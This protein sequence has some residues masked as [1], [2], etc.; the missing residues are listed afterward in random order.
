MLVLAVVGGQELLVC[1][2]LDLHL[3]ATGP[4]PVV[5]VAVAGACFETA[6]LAGPV[7][8]FQCLLSCE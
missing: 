1:V 7:R 8:R 4:W 3:A 5:D 6:T 2:A